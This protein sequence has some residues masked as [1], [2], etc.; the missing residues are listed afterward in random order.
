MMVVLPDAEKCYRRNNIMCRY[1]Y[2]SDSSV[3]VYLHALK[4]RVL[5]GSHP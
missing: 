3:E 2:E 1:I 4:N 5:S